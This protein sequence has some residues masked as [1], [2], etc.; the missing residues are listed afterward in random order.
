M[1][2]EQLAPI[3]IAEAVSQCDADRGIN[4]VTHSMGGILV[5]YYLKDNALPNL[6]N[7][8]MLAPP[9]A[10][11]EI[12]DAL[13][14]WHIF[15][16]INGPAGTQLGTAK[17]NLPSSLGAVTYSVGVIAGSYS[18]NPLLS[19][20]IPGADDGKVAVSK[21]R[22]AGMSD[23]I[24]LP[25]SHPFIM[26]NSEVIKQTLYFLDNGRF[27]DSQKFPHLSVDAKQF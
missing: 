20:I 26:N 6:K 9:N 10:G 15:R 1:P 17:G 5:R 23:H 12:V 3:T 16:W 7:T 11:S 27:M 18:Y 4:F 13:G 25:V 21:T 2:I 22:V 19:Q 24:V 14:G 8:V